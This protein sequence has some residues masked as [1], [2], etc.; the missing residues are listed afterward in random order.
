MGGG[1]GKA[2]FIDAEGTLCEPEC[3]AFSSPFV[4]RPERIVQIAERYE[5][6]P[7]QVLENIVYA[8]AYTS[9]HQHSLITAV[10]AKMVEER[11]A[12]MVRSC[13]KSCSWILPHCRSLILS[14]RSSV[15]TIQAVEN[16]LLD[17]SHLRRL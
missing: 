11:F 9:E 3:R 13:Y 10:A 7:E 16:S 15:W 17:S 8:R 12:L 2:I 14:L 4:S 6:D 1:S 5:L